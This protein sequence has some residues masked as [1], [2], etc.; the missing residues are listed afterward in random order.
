[1]ARFHREPRRGFVGRIAG[2]EAHRDAMAGAGVAGRERVSGR[3]QRVAPPFA[4]EPDALRGEP[5]VE[6]GVE[7]VEIDERIGG[8][9]AEQRRQRVR[10]TD[11][12]RLL[13]PPPIGHD[14]FDDDASATAIEAQRRR[15]AGAEFAELVDGLPQA[16]PRLLAAAFA[17]QERGQPIARHHRAVGEDQVGQQAARLAAERHRARPVHARHPEGAE[18]PRLPTRRIDP[19]RD[20]L[21]DF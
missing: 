6:F 8:P 13:H 18:Q 20:R 15:V 21:A 14:A 9:V 11:L 17:P 5:V 4:D 7:A 3:D 19:A 10:I 1:M 12:G 2:Q 16:R